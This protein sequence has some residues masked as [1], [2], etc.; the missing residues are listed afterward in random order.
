LLYYEEDI[1]FLLKF[2]WSIIDNWTFIKEH[3]LISL[4]V[5]IVI[6][7]FL[8]GNDESETEEKAEVKNTT[9]NFTPIDANMNAILFFRFILIASILTAIISAV[10]DIMLIDTLPHELQRY[11]SS[12]QQNMDA[13]N[14][15]IAAFE[16]LF[17]IVITVLV[18]VFYIGVWNFKRWA[19]ILFI[20]LT[21]FLLLVTP[22]IGEPIITVPW[23]YM[24]SSVSTMLWG[25]LLVL[26]YTAPIKYYF[27]KSDENSPI[28]QSK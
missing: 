15:T 25:M 21:V 28:N 27:S 16:V 22:L 11:L 19:R 9:E 3:W 4:I 5:F 13:V 10:L 7:F 18:T 1:F 6:I 12:Q 24:F 17:I 8:F 2:V 26:M 14:N 23:A 20:V